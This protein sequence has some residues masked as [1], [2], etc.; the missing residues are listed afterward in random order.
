MMPLAFLRHPSLE[1][2][3][4]EGKGQLMNVHDVYVTF[5]QPSCLQ[6]HNQQSMPVCSQ[7]YGKSFIT[8]LKCEVS[9]R[10]FCI[11]HISQIEE[12]LEMVVPRNLKLG[13]LATFSPL[14]TISVPFSE[15]KQ[16]FVSFG[17]IESQVVVFAAFRDFPSM[18]T[19]SLQTLTQVFQE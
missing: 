1:M 13:T 3:F 11:N 2:S 8:V 9:T 5:V 7:L 6:Q 4:I 17:N 16:H 12:G 18:V 15:I 10:S 14:M 19:N